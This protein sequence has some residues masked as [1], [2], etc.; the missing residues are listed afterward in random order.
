MDNQKIKEKLNEIIDKNKILLTFTRGGTSE[1]LK[2][3]LLLAVYQAILRRVECKLVDFGLLNFWTKAKTFWGE[4]IIVPRLAA[5]ELK[6]YGVVEGEELFLTRYIV[7]TLKP[8]DVFLDGGAYVG[9]YTLLASELVGNDG[10]VHSFEPTPRIFKIL[11]KNTLS[12]K[13]VRLNQ[14]ALLDVNGKVQFN[15]F[16]SHHD[17]ANTFLSSEIIP[18][19]KEISRDKKVIEVESVTIDDYC[20]KFNISPSFIKLDIEGSEYNA[21]CGAKRILSDV[22]PIVVAEV[23]SGRGLFSKLISLFNNYSYQP[24]ELNSEGFGELKINIDEFDKEL[25]NPNNFDQKNVVFL[26]EKF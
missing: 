6:R 26:P 4:K 14:K 7:N 18:H 15:D 1:R 20:K 17:V 5:F 16:G 2:K 10:Q 8:G 3:Y 13:N 24:Y 11:S 22:R 12:K 25:N 19:G 21:L 23:W 9:W